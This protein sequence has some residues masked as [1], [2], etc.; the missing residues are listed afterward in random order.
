[1]N[2]FDDKVFIIIKVNSCL[3]VFLTTVSF[4]GQIKL[5]PRR[6]W[7]HLGVYD[8][9]PRTFH[10]RIPRGRISQESRPV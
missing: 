1:M 7:S 9:H 3:S 2:T 4:R 6:D 10:M 5:E 8:E